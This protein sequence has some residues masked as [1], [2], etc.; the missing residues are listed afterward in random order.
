[1]L[2]WNYAY[3]NSRENM[4]SSSIKDT[5]FASNGDIPFSDVNIREGRDFETAASIRAWGWIFFFQLFCCIIYFFYH[6]AIA[7]VS[8]ICLKF[9]DTKINIEFSLPQIP[10]FRRRNFAIS[11][12][13][14]NEIPEIYSKFDIFSNFDDPRSVD[15]HKIVQS[16][17][18]NS[19]NAKSYEV[20][21]FVF[22]FNWC[23]GLVEEE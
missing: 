16:L 3:L 2:K 21:D 4:E 8:P 20:Q 19:S 18:Q 15:G 11:F 23:K 9:I 12:G 10:V 1:M 7:V 22:H 5:F 14:L 6:L 13:V 17:R